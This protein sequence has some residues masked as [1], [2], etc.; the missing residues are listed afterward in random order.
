MGLIFAFSYFSSLACFLHAQDEYILL[1]S[2]KI[3]QGRLLQQDRD[4][5]I[6]LGNDEYL[7]LPQESVLRSF[8]S[9]K[10]LIHYRASVTPLE[11][12]SQNRLFQWFLEQNSPE[13]AL[14]HLKYLEENMDSLPEF[15]FDGWKRIIRNR[16]GKTRAESQSTEIAE[17][18]PLTPLNHFS[19][20][21]EQHLL[22]GC[23]IS[24]CHQT[25]D[26]TAYR[27]HDSLRS[28]ID[29]EQRAESNYAATLA[30]IGRLGKPGFLERVSR[31]HGPLK[32]GMYS[33]VSNEFLAIAT[34]VNSLPNS[35][36]TDA[37][38]L[39]EQ[40][41]A[42]VQ[43]VPARNLPKSI[44]DHS[45]SHPASVHDVK[46][47]PRSIKPQKRVVNSKD[48][49]RIFGPNPN[50]NEKQIQAYRRQPLTNTAFT[51]RDEFDPGIFNRKKIRTPKRP[52]PAASSSLTPVQEPPSRLIFPDNRA[53]R[54]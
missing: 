50:T 40:P 30:T 5:R 17:K 18:T 44:P 48:S 3:L 38:K 26:Q 47:L 46:A 33:P 14:D 49:W 11:T 27:L 39:K 6:E 51:P 42:A 34:W 37:N 25:S 21:V 16:L 19:R 52:S 23:A 20:K 4:S 41:R 12:R 2:G 8:K 1:R 43:S 54:N 45:H 35:T 36:L 28:T 9:L 53:S 22:V 15:D 7:V 29:P 31:K 24:G 32:S 10:D 13:A